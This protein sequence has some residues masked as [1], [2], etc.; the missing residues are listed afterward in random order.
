MRLSLPEAWFRPAL[1]GRSGGVSLALRRCSAGLSARG[2][3]AVDRTLVGT[4]PSSSG[5]ASPLAQP[6]AP[7]SLSPDS[8]RTTLPRRL[9]T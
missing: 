1:L 5:V 7:P 4:L 2:P 6:A 3:L 9:L 8:S